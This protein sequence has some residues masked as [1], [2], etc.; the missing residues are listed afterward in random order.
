MVDDDDGSTI[1]VS[2]FFVL[3]SCLEFRVCLHRRR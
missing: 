3:W 1:L 2:V